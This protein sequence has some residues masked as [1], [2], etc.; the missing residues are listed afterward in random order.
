MSNE[1]NDG[2][3]DAQNPLQKELNDLLVALGATG[4]SNLNPNGLMSIS[5]GYRVW[6]ARNG[7]GVAEAIKP[8]QYWHFTI[9]VPH[10]SGTAAIKGYSEIH[11]VEILEKNAPQGVLRFA[12]EVSEEQYLE[13]REP[14]TIIT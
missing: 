10:G 3:P 1:N 8:K 9:E 12:I 5:R 14:K 11:P 2:P 4:Q 6:R 13:Y 7:P